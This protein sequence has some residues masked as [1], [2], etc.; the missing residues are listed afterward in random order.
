M[1]PVK[2]TKK[3]TLLES[4]HEMATDLYE[5]GVI[6]VNLAK[7]RYYS[8]S[9]SGNN[10]KEQFQDELRLAQKYGKQ[11]PFS[12][13]MHR[14]NYYKITWIYHLLKIVNIFKLLIWILI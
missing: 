2:K 4:A 13:L 9:K 3:L 8:N 14:I 11:Y 6:N 5:A 1:K 12:L 10:F 7:F